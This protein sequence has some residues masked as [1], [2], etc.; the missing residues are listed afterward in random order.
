MSQCSALSAMGPSAPHQVWPAGTF[1]TGAPSTSSGN[2][3]LRRPAGSFRSALSS[4]P[5][6]LGQYPIGPGLSMVSGSYRIRQA[7]VSFRKF[8]SSTV[9]E[10]PTQ[11]MHRQGSYQAPSS[12]ARHSGVV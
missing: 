12:L 2:E 1:P 11:A 8:W 5:T 9:L 10:L 6:S 3:S 4:A 7:G